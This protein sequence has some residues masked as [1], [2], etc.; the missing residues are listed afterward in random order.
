MLINSSL[1]AVTFYCAV[2]RHWFTTTQ[3]I[4]SLGDVVTELECI[5]LGLVET[6]K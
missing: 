6:E 3:N 5:Q 4:Q 1:L 2:I